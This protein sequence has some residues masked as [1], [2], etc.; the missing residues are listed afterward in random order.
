MGFTLGD[1]FL[2]RDYSNEKLSTMSLAAEKFIDPKRFIEGG[3]ASEL[4]NDIDASWGISSRL[5]DASDLDVRYLVGSADPIYNPESHPFSKFHIIINGNTI[6][7]N[8]LFAKHPDF[9]QSV[10]K[11]PDIL[12]ELKTIT[13]D[14]PEKNTLLAKIFLDL[15]RG[16][17]IDRDSVKDI[18][19]EEISDDVIDK[20]LRFLHRVFYLFLIHETVRRPEY[21]FS[22]GYLKGSAHKDDA[23]YLSRGTILT[24]QLMGI[25]LLE[26]GNIKLA[27]L[28][29]RDAPYS[30]VTRKDLRHYTEDEHCK[31]ALNIYNKFMDVF[32]PQHCKENYRISS[33]GIKHILLYGLSSN[34]LEPPTPGGPYLTSCKRPEPSSYKEHL[35]KVNSLKRNL[36]LGN[37][38]GNEVGNEGD[39]RASKRMRKK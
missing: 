5:L 34:Q 2:K 21:K 12:K 39:E 33:N 20:K 10:K 6:K 14:Q 35:T 1:R 9:I 27:D 37:E 16:V 7:L 4:Y 25:I 23:T 3:A 8:N 19:G 30:M 11:Y 38:V 24:T 18:M 31:R 17:N 36:D 15:S 26:N 28:F 13:N 32:A 29:S 22:V